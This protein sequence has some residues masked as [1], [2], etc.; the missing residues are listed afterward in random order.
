[1]YWNEL[2]TGIYPW[3]IHDEGMERILDN[4][5]EHAGNNAAYLVSL[6]HHEKRPP[7]ELQY[8]H[9]PKRKIYIPEDSRAYFRVDPGLYGRI[10]PKE[11]EQDFLKGTDWLDV[12]TKAL[13]KRGMKTG[14]EIS[15]TP[16]DAERAMRDYSDCLQKDVNGRPP[17]AP[18]FGMHIAQQL[19]WNSED[20]VEYVCNLGRDLVRNYDIDVLQNCIIPFNPG[21]YDR[22]P[23]LG[24]FLGGCF[25]K[26]CE[27]KARAAG[28]DWDRLKAEAVHY[29]NVLTQRSPEL[30]EEWLG[31]ERSE[32]SDSQLLLEHPL[33]YEWLRF[34]QNSYTE[35]IR[36]LSEAVHAERKSIDFRFNVCWKRADLFGVNIKELAPHLDSVR[37]QD[38]SEQYGDESAIAE[39]GVWIANIRRQIGEKPIIGGVAVRG[40]ASLKMIESGVTENAKAAVDGLSYGF[41]DGATMERLHVIRDTMKKLE[42]TL[43]NGEE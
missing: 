6:V 33:L 2:T 1:M 39:K 11:T 31:I 8:P 29:N 42:I 22:H 38:Y 26:N 7:Y 16:L 13:R 15:H 24:V 12:F 9:N 5:Q 3:D 25:C 17:M 40:K 23:I 14:A 20:A 34:R 35:F 28:I 36:K 30:R 37:V 19:C 4:L 10:A 21:R 18:V 32:A 43:R 41:Y 27:K